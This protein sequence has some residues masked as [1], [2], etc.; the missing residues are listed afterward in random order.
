MKILLSV[1]TSHERKARSGA[2]GGFED[3][4]LAYYPTGCSQNVIAL[5]MSTEIQQLKR[6]IA[7]KETHREVSKSTVHRQEYMSNYIKEVYVCFLPI[8]QCEKCEFSKG[9]LLEIRLEKSFNQ[10]L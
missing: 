10:N 7:Y 5:L 1:D 8:L 2:G 3:G 4:S 6:V 9:K